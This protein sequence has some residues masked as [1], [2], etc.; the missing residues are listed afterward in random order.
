MASDQGFPQGY[1]GQFHQFE[2]LAGKGDAG[3]GDTKY[4]SA[5]DISNGGEEAAADEPDEVTEEIHIMNIRL[6]EQI[7]MARG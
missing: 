3:D 1:Q 5:D 7:R 4:N 2:M 6:C